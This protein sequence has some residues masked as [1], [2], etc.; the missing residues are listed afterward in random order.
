M[1]AT[2]GLVN[3]FVGRALSLMGQSIKPILAVGSS[4]SHWRVL[5]TATE[6]SL[7]QNF[8]FSTSFKIADAGAV[9]W[10][11]FGRSQVIIFVQDAIFL[12]RIG[13]LPSDFYICAFYPYLKVDWLALVLG[14]RLRANAMAGILARRSFLV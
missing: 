12:T 14:S 9:N 5:I 2:C 13:V 6:A 8:S 3:V 4:D 1:I 10:A 11:F 7:A